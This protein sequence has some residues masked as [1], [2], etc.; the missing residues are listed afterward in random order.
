M[1]VNPKVD[2]VKDENK[3]IDVLNSNGEKAKDKT[4]FDDKDFNEKN[5]VNEEEMRA[6][7]EAKKMKIRKILYPIAIIAI[8]LL[9]LSGLI[10]K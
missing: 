10:E 1:M 2:G 7:K 9:W 8:V 5:F 3:D 6:L 4:P